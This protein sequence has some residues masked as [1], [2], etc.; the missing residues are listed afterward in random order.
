MPSHFNFLFC[1]NVGNSVDSDTGKDGPDSSAKSKLNNEVTFDATSTEDENFHVIQRNQTDKVATAYNYA[2]GV[3]AVMPKMQSLD[4]YTSPPIEELA[5]KERVEPGF[6]CHVKDF[7]V[8]RKGYGSV[9]F[10]GETDVRN[11][12]LESLIKFNYREVIVYSDESKKP[13]VGQGLN[14]PA[15]VTLLNVKCIDKHTGKHYVDGPKVDKWRKLLIK[16]A[17][18]QGAEFVSYDPVIGDWKFRV[19]CF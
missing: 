15:E 11:L 14:K 7:V 17:A 3:E 5:T 18:E 9:K 2:A 1:G 8:G 4:Y 19:Q 6:C 12:D 16:K 10:L 13:Q